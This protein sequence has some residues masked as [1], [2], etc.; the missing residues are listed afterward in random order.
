VQRE[1]HGNLRFICRV[2]HTLSVDE[3]LTAKEEKIESD[4]WASVRALE[5]LAALL[6]DLESYARRHGRDQIGGPHERRIVQARAH[7][8]RIRSV[9]RE[10][11]PVDLGVAADDGLA[12]GMT[13]PLG[14]TGGA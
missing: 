3:L 10:K 11:Q 9:L 13:A 12:D 5:E 1:G 7:A 14:P 2:G 8:D 4:M 6:G